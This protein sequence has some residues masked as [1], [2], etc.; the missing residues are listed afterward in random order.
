MSDIDRNLV[1]IRSISGTRQAFMVSMSLSSL[2]AIDHYMRLHPPTTEE[3]LDSGIAA[4]IEV[5]DAEE[6]RTRA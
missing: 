4:G 1:S 6:A 2:C 5:P 3:K